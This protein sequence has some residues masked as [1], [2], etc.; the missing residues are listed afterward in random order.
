MYSCSFISLYLLVF[1]AFGQ[2]TAAAGSTNLKTFVNARYGYTL[3]Y[4]A[5]WYSQTVSYIF[6]IVSF[7]P[8]TAMRGT[9]LAR[10]GAG[11]NILTAA[12]AVRGRRP[13]PRNLEELVTI[14]TSRENAYER[15]TVDLRDG[16]HALKVIQ[17]KSTCCD[18]SQE[19]VD[20]YFAINDHPFVG[21]VYYWE[22][23]AN[24]G[25]YLTTLSQIILSLRVTGNT[26]GH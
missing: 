2:P 16:E 17:T 10:N 7:L 22:G 4:P 25:K 19:S 20:W 6:S 13:V 3:R 26:R 24:A 8:S 18:P 23:D 15:S 1:T 5:N 9:G 21:M 14:L 12:Q 11:I